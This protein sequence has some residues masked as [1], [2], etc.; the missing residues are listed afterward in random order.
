MAILF[1]FSLTSNHLH[2]LQV[3]NCE[4]NSRLVADEDDD[5]EFRIERVKHHIIIGGLAFIKKIPRTAHNA[6]LKVV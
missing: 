6:G 5:G 4:S 3:E 1:T 2:P